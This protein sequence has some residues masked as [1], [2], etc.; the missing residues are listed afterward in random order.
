MTRFTRT[1]VSDG[2]MELAR[3]MARLRELLQ[4]RADKH[5][6]ERARAK[7][8]RKRQRIARKRQRR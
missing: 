8:A 6:T 4:R 7:A 5:A 2:A 1:T 3:S